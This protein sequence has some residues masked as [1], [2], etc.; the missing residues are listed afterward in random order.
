MARRWYET[1]IRIKTTIIREAC[2]GPE[3]VNG[4]GGIGRRPGIQKNDAG[5]WSAPA[6][7]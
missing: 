7:G 5:L 2:G 1:F 4:F 6:F 3:Y